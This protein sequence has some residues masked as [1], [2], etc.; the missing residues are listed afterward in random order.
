M[1][2]RSACTNKTAITVYGGFYQQNIYFVEVLRHI[3]MT[4]K[5]YRYEFISEDFFF[6]GPFCGN[7]PD[8]PCTMRKTAKYVLS[9]MYVMMI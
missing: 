1:R 3:N 2:A 6:N 7:L 9:K 4:I 5:L 8:E